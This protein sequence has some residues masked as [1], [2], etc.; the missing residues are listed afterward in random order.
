MNTPAIR[1]S[2]SMSHVTADTDRREPARLRFAWH[3]LL[4]AAALC[5]SEAQA[6]GAPVSNPYDQTRTSSFTYYGTSDGAK[7]GL[8]KSEIVQPLTS[9]TPNAQL[10]VVTTYD[11]DAYGNKISANT[12]N[13]AGASG[14]A[15]F[16]TRGSSSAFASQTVTVA[17]VSVT[18]PAGGFATTSTSAANTALSQSENHTFDPRFGA[19]TSLTG[20]NGLT[21]TWVIDDLGRKTIEIRADLTRTVNTYCFIAGQVSDSGTNSGG[22][23]T[24]NPAP[25]S[26]EIPADAVAFV[27]S[28]PHNTSDV[29]SGPFAR[30]YTDRAGRTIRSVT[31]AFDGSTQLGGMNRL[32]VQDT[33]YSPYGP[34][35]VATQPYFLD[36]GISTSNGS[37]PYGMSL[38]TYDVLGR[39]IASYTTDSAGSQPARTVTLGSHGLNTGNLAVTRVLYEGLTTTTT[40]DK[41]QTRVEEKNID[42]KLVRA[43]D[44]LGA[45]IAYQH[46]AFGNLVVTKDAL[47]NQLVVSYD[48]RGRKVAMNDLDTG[49][50]KYDYDAMGQ[51][52]WQQ[53]AN[54]LALSQ[55][56]TMV[57]DVLGR[58]TQRTEPE[59]VS[60]WRYDTYADGSPCMQGTAPRRGAGKLCES[61]ATNGVN[62]KVLYDALGRPF[63]A[64]TTVTNG[65]SFAT[66]VAYDSATG[67]LAS[68][69]YPTGL[70]VNYG[71]TTK[72]FLS[73]MTLATAATVNPRPATP[74]GVA[75]ATTPLNPLL[76]SAGSYNAWGKAELQTVGYGVSGIATSAASDGTTGRLLTLSAGANNTVLNYS[77]GWDSLNRLTQR[78]DGNGDGNTGAVTESFT[79]DSIGRLQSYDVSAYAIPN[80]IRSVTLQYNALGMLLNKSDVG[81]YVYGAQNTVG[82]KPHA[83]VSISGTA[84]ASYS[85]DANGN[86]KTAT[87]GA[88]RAI[89]YTSFNLPDNNTGA[90][91]PAGGPQYAWQYDENHQRIKETHVSAGI[92]RTTW[93]AHPDNQGGLGFES[94]SSTASTTPMNRHYLSVGGSAIGVLVNNAALPVLGTGVMAPP[95][96]GS[97]TLVKVEY[98]HKD[99]LGSLITTTDH[100][101]AVTQRYA[102]DPFGKRRY[103]NG[104]YDT[105]GALIIDWTTDTNKGTD[106]GGTRGMNSS[107][108]SASCT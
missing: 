30:I 60:T 7:N 65:P 101:G 58:M 69:T 51:L 68:Q 18:I 98:W 8:L 87:N 108:T 93:Y 106:R 92:T 94:E 75:G 49:V 36:S 95:T 70:R 43:T 5:A 40:N 39:P 80:T 15:L 56:T 34:Q 83:L 32:I 107:T 54:Q 45:Q 66:A 35:T 88:Y 19:M 85:Y 27:H 12:A 37:T 86:L 24:L 44:A 50:W 61:N 82:V 1:A 13:C 14:N 63:N 29:K 31:E 21:T 84:S 38:T 28:E 47:Q 96:I 52:V 25:T 48:A 20:P 67:R 33:E 55:T 71:Y 78:N 73:N 72:G 41:K 16:T 90:Q 6:E 3:G 64:R 10:C 53:S 11:Y 62:R 23:A 9:A 104:T 42:G 59:Y 79:H 26:A 102:Y 81:N 57:Y 105:F 91:G 89:A 97:I 77:F 2:T 76:W 22:C 4:L 46:D 100:T 103:T 99:H 17:G 74:G